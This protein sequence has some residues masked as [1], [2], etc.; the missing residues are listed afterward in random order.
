MREAEAEG[1]ELAVAEVKRAGGVVS[2]DNASL[3][4]KV[5]SAARPP[6]VRRPP[7]VAALDQA[8]LH[9]AVTL[10]RIWTRSGKRWQVRSKTR[11]HQWTQSRS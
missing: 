10:C 7:L 2:L 6:Y 8:L 9:V 3:T 5:L 4:S 1:A 11:C